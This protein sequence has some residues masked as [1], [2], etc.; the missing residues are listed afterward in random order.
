MG[1]VGT[2]TNLIQR[3]LDYTL[4]RPNFATLELTFRC[5]LT[6]KTCGVWRDSNTKE[7][8][9]NEIPFDKLREIFTDLK[10]MGVK[11]ISLL[12][13]ETLIR[14]DILDI[15]RL[16][17]EFGFSLVVTTNATMISEKIAED[18]VKIGVDV[19]NYS[20]DAAYDDH[21]SIRGIPGTFDRAKRGIEFVR[22]AKKKYNSKLPHT[23]AA[24]TI[25]KLNY[26]TFD[27]L[28]PIAREMEVDS[29]A[30]GY[31][32]E[33]SAEDVANTVFDGKV[34]ST[35]YFLPND[36]KTLLLNDDEISVFRAKIKELE[37]G[38]Y[39]DIAYTGTM[40]SLSDDILKKGRY[41]INKCYSSRTR[42]IIDPVGNVI[43]CAN[44]RELS[45][46]N[47]KEQSIQE[48]W[49]GDIRKKFI[50]KLE[51]GLM[52]VCPNCCHSGLNLTL[53][54]SIKKILDDKLR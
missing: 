12:G 52:P 16:V 17:K 37:K 53:M 14:K 18:I 46:G 48:I 5:N 1:I 13:G 36:D 10:R 49:E 30:L 3:E 21:D 11:K 8:I 15:F 47:V 54:Q 34:V 7:F 24:T 2:L 42:I 44:L 23:Y 29:F 38:P 45:Y 32:S 35:D 25:S 27:K 19:I 4:S 51:N 40:N 43:P 28:A 31:L 33:T 6:C 26:S 50:K 39:K 41:K 9:R 22:D 20:L